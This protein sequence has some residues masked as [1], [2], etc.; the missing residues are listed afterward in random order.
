M[1]LSV[2]ILDTCIKGLIFCL[3]TEVIK[4]IEACACNF[5]SSY[6]HGS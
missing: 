5:F 4:M 2:H 6:S 3:D 1:F